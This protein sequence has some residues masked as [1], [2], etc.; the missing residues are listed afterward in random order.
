MATKDQA[1]DQLS[2]LLIWGS[3]GAAVTILVITM[4]G[5][6]GEERPRY[7]NPKHMNPRNY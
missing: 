3:L 5:S 6:F 1:D 4:A 7:R 2:A